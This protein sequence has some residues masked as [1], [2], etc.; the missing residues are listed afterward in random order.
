MICPHC[1]SKEFEKVLSFGKF[2]YVRC[3]AC[4]LVTTVPMPSFSEISDYYTAKVKGGNYARFNPETETQK[5]NIF[6]SYLRS[7]QS[8]TG[9]SVK[10]K[11]VLDVGC[12]NGF[13]LS[14]IKE[15]G[16]VPFGVELQKEAAM[17]AASRFPGHV[18]QGDALDFVKFERTFDVITMSDV[19]EHL[20]DPFDVISKLR[21]GLNKGGYLIL[22]TPNTGSFMCRLLGK[23]WPSY[24]PIHHINIFNEKNLAEMLQQRGFEVV[25]IKPLWKKLSLGYVKSILPHLSPVLGRFSRLIPGFLDKV[26]CPLNGGEMYLIARAV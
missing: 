18:L 8:L 16:G 1:D 22:T 13:S 11:A 17:E 4:R 2:E 24:T 5:Q 20:V 6:K 25:S 15:Y 12:F 19:I 14:A 26:S 21:Q 10:D 7:F 3:S 23:V 9:S